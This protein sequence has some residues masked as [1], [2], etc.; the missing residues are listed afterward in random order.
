MS[1]EAG[2]SG[3]LDAAVRRLERA[4]GQ[5]ELRIDA[6]V[7]EAGGAA[8]GLFEQDRAKLAADLDAARGRERE[9]EEA[10]QLAS[11]ALG[12]AIA[13]IRAALGPE[14]EN[15]PGKHDSVSEEA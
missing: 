12:R 9:L 6:L 14:P 8:A 1:D 13:D 2:V 3:A 15:D 11:A 7:S 4:V 10:G 5:L